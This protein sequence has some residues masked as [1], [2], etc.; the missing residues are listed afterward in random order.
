[1]L[2]TG[3]EGHAERQG[4]D[5][6]AESEG[7]TESDRRNRGTSSSGILRQSLSVIL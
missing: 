5:L 7:G 6:D 2:V 1:M 3:G 4:R